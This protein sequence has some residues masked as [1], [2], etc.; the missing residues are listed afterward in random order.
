[1]TIPDSTRTYRYVADGRL[2]TGSGRQALARL[3]RPRVLTSFVLIGLLVGVGL[4]VS[5]YDASLRDHPGRVLFIGAVWGVA[6]MVTVATIVGVLVVPAVSVAN[7]RMVSRLFPEGS[8]TE[9]ELDRDGFVIRRRTGTRS[10]PYRSLVRVRTSG[11][12]LR[13]ELRGRPVAELLPR[14]LLPDDVLELLRARSR[15]VWPTTATVGQ[16]TPDRT[17]VVPTGWATR[18]AAAATTAALR[19]TGFWLRSGLVLLAS[20]LLA[21][22]VDPRWLL[23]GL[24]PPLLSLALTYT[25]TR[26]NVAAVLPAGS[27]ASTEFLEDRFVSRNMGGAREIRFDDIRSIDVRGDVV[28]LGLVSR[29]SPLVIARVLVPDDQLARLSP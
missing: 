24:V 9:V 11:S 10:I 15:D 7:R 5:A 16:G 26:R 8:V 25:G 1:V 19:R 27:V 6:W 23:L 28:F 4:S 18:V 21:I 13:L 12:L 17:M 3:L 20:V 2:A 22:A 14:E 29:R